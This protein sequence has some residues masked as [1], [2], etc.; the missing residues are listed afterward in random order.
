MRF[1]DELRKRARD[2]FGGNPT[3]SLCNKE[4]W[5]FHQGATMLE[6]YEHLAYATT[7]PM[8]L[9]V[10]MMTC[11]HCGNTHLL[12]LAQLNLTHLI[13]DEAAA[14]DPPQ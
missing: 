7:T 14:H 2:H 9:T 8:T 6:G 12:S 11:K 10:G 4:D 1:A 5:L 13:P 3:C